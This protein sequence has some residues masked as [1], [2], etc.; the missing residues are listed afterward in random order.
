MDTKKGLRC[1]TSFLLI[2]FLKLNL[3]SHHLAT[4]MSSCKWE[5]VG[6]GCLGLVEAPGLYSP[7]SASPPSCLP[8]PRLWDLQSCAP[9]WWFCHCRA[10]KQSSVAVEGGRAK[11]ECKAL[12][13]LGA[14]LS[15]R[16]VEPSV[17]RP[18]A[19]PK[20]ICSSGG[21]HGNRLAFLADPG[22]VLV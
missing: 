4:K 14:V 18:K 21:V 19:A 17:Q 1:P 16:Y 12:R 13:V 5:A 3:I 8:P 22:A 9:P 15:P 20:L 6:L 2:D 11:L 7:A 10:R